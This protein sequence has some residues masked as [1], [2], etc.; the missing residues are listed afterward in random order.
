MKGFDGVGIYK[1]VKTQCQNCGENVMAEQ[2]S[3]M[4]KNF[5]KLVCINCGN[6]FVRK[7]ENLRGKN[8]EIKV[9][10]YDSDEE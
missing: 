2:T 4:N 1:L 6:Q 7:G 8:P 3:T 10:I 9:D 5:Y